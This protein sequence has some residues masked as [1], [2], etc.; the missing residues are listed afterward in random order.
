MRHEWRFH[1]TSSKTTLALEDFVFVAID[2]FGRFLIG[3]YLAIVL[4]DF[5]KFR[6]ID[7]V[8]ADVTLGSA[9][10]ALAVVLA[11]CTCLEV[12][13]LTIAIRQ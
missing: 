5:D 6:A 13:H 12:R 11:Q 7:I 10:D 4:I 8:D 9:D 3:R 2:H 1:Q